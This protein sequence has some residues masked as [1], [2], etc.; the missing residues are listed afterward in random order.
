MLR[1]GS[2]L[3]YKPT[4]NLAKDD[5][6][7][8]RFTRLNSNRNAQRPR[9]ND[10]LNWRYGNPSLSSGSLCVV[11]LKLVGSFEYML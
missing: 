8:L 3:S 6:G 11:E 10:S 4:E 7:R 2:G 1:Y 5:V 9:D